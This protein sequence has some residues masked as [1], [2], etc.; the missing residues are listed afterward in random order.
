MASRYTCAVSHRGLG[1]Y[2]VISG[3]DES[4]VT[5]QARAL[6]LEWEQNCQHLS[7]SHAA[8]EGR[9]AEIL[10]AIETIRNILRTGAG[11]PVEPDWEKLKHYPPFTKPQPK[12]PEYCTKFPVEPQ[13]M[14]AIYQPRLSIGKYRGAKP[15]YREI[16]PPPDRADAKYQTEAG[17]LDKMVKS[18]REEKTR[19]CQVHFDYDYNS[20]VEEKRQIEIENQMRADELFKQDHAAWAKAVDEINRQNQEIYN[21]NVAEVEAW[22]RES[23]AYHQAMEKRVAAIARRQADF[24]SFQAQGIE[25]YCQTACALSQYPD[26]IPQD[27]VLE[28]HPDSKTFVVEY[29]ISV[30]GA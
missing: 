25:D 21:Q 30:F 15:I 13:P 18:R 24:K 7:A 8:P 11:S 9:E 3:L 5:A 6:E 27:F 10:K 23:E 2:T 1:K 16:P 22:N 26:R 29:S 14:D 19:A 4:P 20:W 12:P 28:Y 17:L